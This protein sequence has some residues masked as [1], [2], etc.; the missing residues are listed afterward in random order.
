LTPTCFIDALHR[1]AFAQ[2][3]TQRL[4]RKAAAHISTPLP[5]FVHDIFS[6][7]MMPQFKPCQRNMTVRGMGAE[8]AC[9]RRVVKQQ[10]AGVDLV[11]SE[12]QPT[13]EGIELM[14]WLARTS[15]AKGLVTFAAYAAPRLAKAVGEVF[16][17]AHSGNAN[18]PSIF[19][20]LVPDKPQPG[21]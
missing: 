9:I 3:Y 6:P 11:Y 12:K 13:G 2:V 7:F 5:M 15:R 8:V 21:Q 17:P 4:L 19:F 18:N 16:H 14:S 20:Q 1:N 10:P